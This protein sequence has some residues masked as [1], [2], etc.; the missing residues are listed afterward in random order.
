[1]DKKD[2]TGSSGIKID[3]TAP[4]KEGYSSKLSGKIRKV[5]NAFQSLHNW[6]HKL[7]VKW[8]K[9]KEEKTKMQED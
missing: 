5:A 2:K 3:F 8:T 4:L 9:K 1:M 6:I 7:S